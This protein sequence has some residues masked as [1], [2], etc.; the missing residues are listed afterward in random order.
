MVLPL[1]CT[2]KP[3]DANAL[4]VLDPD[5]QSAIG[6]LIG[7]ED[8]QKL[9]LVT[10]FNDDRGAFLRTVY[11]CICNTTDDDCNLYDFMRTNT[12]P[13]DPEFQKELN[14]RWKEKF[15][16]QSYFFVEGLYYPEPAGIMK[17]EAI[18]YPKEK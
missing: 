1:G 14:A 6:S 17:V 12:H 10:I 2:K 15:P 13:S 11:I 3:I 9:A 4:V 16:S 5:A 8:G 7:I 18:Y